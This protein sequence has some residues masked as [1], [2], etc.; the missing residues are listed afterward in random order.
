MSDEWIF[1][2]KSMSK[3]YERINDLKGNSVKDAYNRL[4][5]HLNSLP[6]R[7][8]KADIDCVKIMDLKDFIVKDE[9]LTFPK[10]T[11]FVR[12]D[13]L[14]LSSEDCLFL[15]PIF[16]PNKEFNDEFNVMCSFMHDGIYINK[17]H[18]YIG[19]Q[20]TRYQKDNLELKLAGYHNVRCVI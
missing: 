15:K 10:Y 16:A 7:N 11:F 5:E 6:R 19:R 4:G 2:D 14:C 8:K 13:D 20:I 9:F 1:D 18:I 3:L 12:F 17:K